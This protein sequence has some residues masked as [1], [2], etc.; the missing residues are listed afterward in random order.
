MFTYKPVAKLYSFVTDIDIDAQP[1]ELL[2]FFL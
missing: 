1:G 2:R